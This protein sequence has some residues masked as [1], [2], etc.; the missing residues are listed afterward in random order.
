V[1]NDVEGRPPSHYLYVRLDAGRT[2]RAETARYVTAM[3]GDRVVLIRKETPLLACISH[4]ITSRGGRECR[5]FASL[6]PEGDAGVLE[7]YVEEPGGRSSRRF[8]AIGR[9]SRDLVRNAG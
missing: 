5:R 1:I 2:V 6:G 3:P 7:Q 8:G 9:R 4:Q